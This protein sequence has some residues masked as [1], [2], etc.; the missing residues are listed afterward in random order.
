MLF[1][2]VIKLFSYS[3]VTDAKENTDIDVALLSLRDLA[4]QLKNLGKKEKSILPYNTQVIRRRLLTARHH[5]FTMVG[6]YR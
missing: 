3:P 5:L 4:D 1:P 6:I 2:I